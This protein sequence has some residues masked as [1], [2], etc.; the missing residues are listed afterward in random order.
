MLMNIPASAYANVMRA[1]YEVATESPDPSTQNGALIV[2]DAM[3]GGHVGFEFLARGSN[4]FTRGMESTP[5]RLERP[6]KYTFVEH[7]ER[8]AIFHA[9]SLGVN[10]TDMTMVCPWAACTECARAIVQSGIGKLVR[11]KQASDRSP[12]RWIESIALAD[13]ILLASGIKII[14][15]DGVL[16]EDN[17]VVGTVPTIMHCEEEWTP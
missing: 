7:A 12:E 17:T 4:T 14:E 13:E 15:F 10:C 2:R 9:A 16:H 5:E 6:L 8:N 1:A 11:H 3:I